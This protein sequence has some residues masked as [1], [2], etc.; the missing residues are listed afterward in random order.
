MR[1]QYAYELWIK[2]VREVNGCDGQKKPKPPVPPIVDP[3]TKIDLECID[4]YNFAKVGKVSADGKTVKV[5]PKRGAALITIMKDTETD[6]FGYGTFVVTDSAGA[7]ISSGTYRC[8]SGQWK[9]VRNVPK[10]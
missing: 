6:S 4:T 10:S 5:R 3:K 2:A 8:D 7:E 9:M 1:L